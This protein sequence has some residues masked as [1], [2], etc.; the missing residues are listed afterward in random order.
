M[1]CVDQEQ[2]PEQKVLLWQACLQAE[3]KPRYFKYWYRKIFKGMN[4]RKQ[5]DRSVCSL[6]YQQIGLSKQKIKIVLSLDI[7]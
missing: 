4:L 3:L 5:K 6:C 1:S 7:P 2:E